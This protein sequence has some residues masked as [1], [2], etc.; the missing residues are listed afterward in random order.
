MQKWSDIIFSLLNSFSAEHIQLPC[1]G[2]CVSFSMEMKKSVNLQREMQKWTIQ[3][4]ILR[5][6]NSSI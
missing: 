3:L 5:M 1:K 4:S 2:V 6:L